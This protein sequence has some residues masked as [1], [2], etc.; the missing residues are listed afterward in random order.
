MYICVSRIEWNTLTW[1]KGFIGK[2]ISFKVEISEVLG[3]FELKS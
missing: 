3:L 1:K 2:W